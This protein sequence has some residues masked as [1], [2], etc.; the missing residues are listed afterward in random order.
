MDLTAFGPYALNVR[1][2]MSSYGP[3]ARLIRAY[4]FPQ[5][6]VIKEINYR[7]DKLLTGAIEPALKSLRIGGETEARPIPSS[8]FVPSDKRSPELPK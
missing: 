3:R 7:K 8:K 4:S 1:T 6:G 5:A 2:N